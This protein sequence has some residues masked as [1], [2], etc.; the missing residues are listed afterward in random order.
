MSGTTNKPHPFALN[1]NKWL[2][3]KRAHLRNLESFLNVFSISEIKI[4]PVHDYE[5]RY[6][7]TFVITKIRT[8]KYEPFFIVGGGGGGGGAYSCTYG[9]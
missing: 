6:A 2:V 8:F 1:N 5:K 4:I 7:D 3:F 9:T